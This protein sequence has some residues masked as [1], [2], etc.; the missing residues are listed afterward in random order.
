MHNDQSKK[1]PLAV[2]DALGGKIQSN[3][4]IFFYFGFFVDG[5]IMDSF[6]QATVKIDDLLVHLVACH[7]LCLCYCFVSESGENIKQALI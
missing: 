3:Y 7:Y 1:C 6:S 4:H 5:S 2:D